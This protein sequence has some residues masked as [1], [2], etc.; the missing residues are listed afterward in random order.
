MLRSSSVCCGL[1]FYR[2]GF[3]LRAFVG[4]F[5]TRARRIRRAC[6]TH[7]QQHPAQKIQN[8]FDFASLGQSGVGCP[9]KL[10]LA[11]GKPCVGSCFGLASRPSRLLGVR[12]VCV[13]AA[14]P[15]LF[16]LLALSARLA[17]RNALG[18]FLCLTGAEWV[19]CYFVFALWPGLLNGGVLG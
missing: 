15:A 19:G 6:H 2:P 9:A 17:L 13:L 12:G 7:T 10:L 16:L 8:K 4:S 5:L 14:W 18:S 3:V 11:Y 1:L